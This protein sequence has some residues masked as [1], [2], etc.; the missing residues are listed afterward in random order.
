SVIDPPRSVER[1]SDAKFDQHG[2]LT[3][4]NGLSL[5]IAG[6]PPKLSLFPNFTSQPCAPSMVWSQPARISTVSPILR[7]GTTCASVSTATA[8]KPGLRSDCERI[9]TSSV[10]ASPLIT[11]KRPPFAQS[12]FRAVLPRS[13]RTSRPSACNTDVRTLNA[14]PVGPEPF[15]STRQPG[16]YSVYGQDRPSESTGNSR[17]AASFATIAAR[18]VAS[19]LLSSMPSDAISPTNTVSMSPVS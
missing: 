7:P 11:R 4:R 18:N 15:S 16:P 1:K 5:G 6:D 10:A 12:P 17:R 2:Y 13:T 9:A 8:E 3:Q 19:V 14:R